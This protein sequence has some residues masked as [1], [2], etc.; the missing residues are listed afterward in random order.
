MLRIKF[1]RDVIVKKT[2]LILFLVL[3][4]TLALVAVGLEAGMR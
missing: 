1:N 2:F 3:T 4:G